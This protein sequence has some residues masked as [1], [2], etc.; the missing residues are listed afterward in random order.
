MAGKDE[1]FCEAGS[2]AVIFFEEKRLYDFF[3]KAGYRLFDLRYL[4]MDDP[5]C[6]NPGVLRRVFFFPADIICQS[7]A[8]LQ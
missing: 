6:Q 2:K 8:P 1:V 4:P 3:G 5:G 7:I